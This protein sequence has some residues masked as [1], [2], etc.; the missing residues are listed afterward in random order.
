MTSSNYDPLK[1]GEV[2]LGEPD[3][4][5]EQVDRASKGNQEDALI[6]GSNNSAEPA[7][8]RPILGNAP[9]KS[10]PRHRNPLPS[11]GPAT[12]QGSRTSHRADAEVLTRPSTSRPS[13]SRPSASRTQASRHGPH[14]QS[15]RREPLPSRR[16]HAAYSQMPM[17]EP[18]ASRVVPMVVL[19]VGLGAAGY[20]CLV[21]QQYPLAIFLALITLVAAPLARLI[22]QGAIE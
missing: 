7:R 12:E 21:A 14:S 3:D 10:G 1:F 9:P 15:G 20:L 11:Q 6:R 8:T 4:A 16:D 2:S 19:F 17:P 5:Q 22:F 13:T 18:P